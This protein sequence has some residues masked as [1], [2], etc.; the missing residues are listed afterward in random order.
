MDIRT[1]VNEQRGCPVSRLCKCVLH[2]HSAV[3]LNYLTGNIA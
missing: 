2:V 1:V 3:N